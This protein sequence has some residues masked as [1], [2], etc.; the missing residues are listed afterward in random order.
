[1]N[2]KAEDLKLKN[3][4]EEHPS[5]KDKQTK[6]GERLL[7]CLAKIPSIWAQFHRAAHFCLANNSE[8][9]FPT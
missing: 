6:K 7:A 1:M 5:K 8:A 4:K 2:S 9:I 3:P